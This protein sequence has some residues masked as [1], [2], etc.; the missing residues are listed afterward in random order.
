MFILIARK[1]S[2]SSA[3]KLYNIYIY[4][5]IYIYTQKNK[6]INLTYIH[7]KVTA[8]L[9]VVNFFSALQIIKMSVIVQAITTKF[10]VQKFIAVS[11]LR[12]SALK[13]VVLGSITN[14][15]MKNRAVKI[16]KTIEP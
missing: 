8:V 15:H 3:F 6:I 5:Y 7:L 12:K 13:L 2:A 1:D 14:I 16:V 4:L 10:I 11:L 9:L